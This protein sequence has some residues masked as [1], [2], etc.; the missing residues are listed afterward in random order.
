M[1]IKSNN[2]KKLYEKYMIYICVKLFEKQRM[3]L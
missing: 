1:L 2:Y 3:T